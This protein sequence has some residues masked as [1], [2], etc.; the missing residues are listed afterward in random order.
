MNSLL[1]AHLLALTLPIPLY[2]TAEAKT[3]RDKL[4]EVPPRNLRYGRDIGIPVRKCGQGVGG[5]GTD[6]GRGAQCWGRLDLGEAGT[7]LK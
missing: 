6:G 7:S 2:P 4:L 3:P 5:L 1:P